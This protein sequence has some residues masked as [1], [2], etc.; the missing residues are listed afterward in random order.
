M[1][2]KPR[3][4]YVTGM[5]KSIRLLKKLGSPNVE[6]G[7]ASYEASA[8][9]A[10]EAALQAPVRTGALRASI[11]PVRKQYGASVKAGNSKV[12][13]GNPIHWGWFYDRNNFIKKNIRPNPFMYR[14]FDKRI[15]EVMET[16]K[17]NMDAL[18][19]KWGG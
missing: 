15:D 3:T 9:M 5:N 18:I 14:A 6:I 2:Y 10:T 19:K 13:Y 16:Y 11:R 12:V 4:A 7:V 1:A 8:I 17:K